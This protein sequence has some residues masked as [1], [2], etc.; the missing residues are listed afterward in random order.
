MTLDVTSTTK[1]Q[2]GYAV[3]LSAAK[4]VEERGD[5]PPVPKRPAPPD[6]SVALLLQN[7][8]DVLTG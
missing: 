8:I 5:R 4:G 7:D 1:D 2:N 3:T 6:S